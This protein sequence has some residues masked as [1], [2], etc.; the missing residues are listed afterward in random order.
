MILSQFTANLYEK[1]ETALNQIFHYLRGTLDVGIIYYAAKSP[2]P[3]GFTDASFAH[4]I[5]KEGR[6]STS[7]Y[8]FFIASGPVSW[9]Y[10]QQFTIATSST[11]AEYI[12]QYNAA[13]EGV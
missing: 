4:P 5:V 10:K 9:S 12:G 3:F 13:Q 1:H 2:I 11:K 6:R 8:I 7:G